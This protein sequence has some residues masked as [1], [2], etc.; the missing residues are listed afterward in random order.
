MWGNMPSAAESASGRLFLPSLA[1]AYFATGPLGVL[2]GLLLIDIAST[3]EVSVGVMG[4]I[5]TPYYVVAVIFALFM[6]VLSVRFRHKSL[7]MAGL[8]SVTISAVGCFF[9]QN[10][11]LMLTS[12]ALSGMGTAMVTPMAITLIGDH[13]PLEKR[14]HAIGWIVASGALSYVLGAPIIGFIAA[15]RGW[16]FVILAFV[17]PISLASL[18]LAFTSLPSTSH[19]HHPAPSKTVYLG[20]FKDVVSNRSATACLAGNTLRSIAFMVILLY[21]ISF[22]REQFAVSTA[23]ASVV[24]LAAALCYTVGSLACDRVVNRF[25]R[26]PSTVATAL[27]GGLLAISFA[28][29]PNLWLSLVLFV[30][31]SWFFGIGASAANSLTLE[32]VP[33]LRGTMMSLTSA[34]QS[35]G[36]ALGA[37]LGGV[38]LVLYNYRIMGSTLGALGIVAALVFYLLSR[39]PTKP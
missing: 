34:A 7:L 27:L 18:L 17:L 11:N 22:F 21:G 10:F 6:G 5:N 15:L 30:S 28:F 1:F 12:Y 9:A 14:T 26:K 13:L 4:Q 2:T 25:G 8:G 36:S 32:Q 31:S 24:M 20:S 37:A 35:L 39:D 19:R 3:F 29:L 33:R 23:F 38:L 16:R